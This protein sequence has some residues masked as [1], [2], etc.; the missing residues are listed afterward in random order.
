MTTT[1]TPTPPPTPPHHACQDDRLLQTT[2]PYCGVGCGVDVIQRGGMQGQ[3][4]QLTGSPEHPANY[5]RLCIKGTHLLETLDKHKRLTQPVVFGQ[6]ATWDT[7]TK[8]IAGR[9]TQ[10]IEQYGLT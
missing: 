4:S 1:P 2:C 5:G 8:E 9:L 7:A 6:V 3:L 10:I